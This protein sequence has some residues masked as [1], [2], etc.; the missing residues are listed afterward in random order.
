M[1][2][3]RRRDCD[4]PSTPVVPHG[5][6][7]SYSCACKASTTHHSCL[8]CEWYF[9]CPW[10][11]NICKCKGPSISRTGYGL[12]Q[13]VHKICILW[14][15]PDLVSHSGYNR[16]V[17]HTHECVSCRQVR[18]T[19][20]LSGLMRIDKYSV[21]TLHTLQAFSRKAWTWTSWHTWAVLYETRRV[22]S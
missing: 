2:H 6:L 8:R 21:H 18:G 15:A 13:P 16:T 4:R 10:V 7:I 19:Y 22:T 20:H 9:L 17:M 5:S 14:L 11:S 12:S 3:T 1:L